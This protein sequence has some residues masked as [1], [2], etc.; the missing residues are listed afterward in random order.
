M[1]RLAT[2]NVPTLAWGSDSTVLSRC[3]KAAPKLAEA[4]L[5][6]NGDRA[7]AGLKTEPAPVP[8]SV[9]GP[10]LPSTR[11]FRLD[12]PRT[13]HMRVALELE[14]RGLPTKEAFRRTALA[15]RSVE[16]G[17]FGVLFDTNRLRYD[18]DCFFEH[19]LACTLCE[20]FDDLEFDFYGLGMPAS[21]SYLEVVWFYFR[22]VLQTWGRQ[23][24][25]RDRR[26]IVDT[27]CRC[28]DAP[29]SEIEKALHASAEG[30]L[31]YDPD[32]PAGQRLAE[33]LTRAPDSLIDTLCMGDVGA[34]REL[35][36][37]MQQASS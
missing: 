23:E 31:K 2:L 5:A 24:V 6:G 21:R 1:V 33:I 15:F 32:L 35:V 8:I 20:D 12:G 16:W 29:R 30:W 13:L 28:R 18:P 14:E 3:V 4:I 26:E 9:G 25:M 34:V 11:V 27:L 7:L 10:E 37:K 17:G 36:W 19:A 22:G